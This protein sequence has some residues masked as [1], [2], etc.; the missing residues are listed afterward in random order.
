[1]EI[2]VCWPIG[3]KFGTRAKDLNDRVIGYNWGK[4]LDVCVRGEVRFI[5]GVKILPILALFWLLCTHTI[6]FRVVWYF[7]ICRILSSF[8]H[9][10]N[11]DRAWTNIDTLPIYIFLFWQAFDDFLGPL[12][13]ISTYSSIYTRSKHHFEYNLTLIQMSEV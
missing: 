12:N 4:L 13:S 11:G 9:A 6:N 1:M 2:Y 7:F 5:L 3:T 8:K 10:M